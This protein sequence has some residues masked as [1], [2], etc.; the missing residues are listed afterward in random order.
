MMLRHFFLFL[1]RRRSLRRWMETSSLSHKF[2]RRFVAGQ[3][4]EDAIRTGARLERDRYLFTLDHLGENVTNAAEAEAS[5][6]DLEK[7][8]ES[9]RD[10]GLKAT[11][12]VKLTQLGLDLSEQI[13]GR[14]MDVLCRLAREMGSRVE[15]DM[16]SH[17]YVDRTLALVERL[18]GE[19]GCVRAVLQAYLYRTAE[20]LERLNRL[21]I[22]V[23]LC[24]GAYDEPPEVAF[25]KKSEVDASYLRLTRALMERG[26]E[27][28]I[29]THD[30]KMIDGALEAARANGRT[31]S[32]FEFQMLYGVRRDLQK[33]LVERGFRVRLYVPYGDAWYPYFM[34]RLAERPANVLFIVKNLVRA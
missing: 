24:K 28:A 29:A 33:S 27:P 1:S 2:T 22:P 30:P 6:R 12:S 19:Y 32:D 26:T 15:I 4:L 3:R 14:H 5:R 9:I 7:G 11:I 8:L 16:E 18:H 13:C 31:A 20:D 21:K 10:A 25:P 34:R 23:R 17:E